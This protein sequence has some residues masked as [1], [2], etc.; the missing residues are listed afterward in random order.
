MAPR[1]SD[2]SSLPTKTCGSGLLCQARR[3]QCMSEPQETPCS[4]KSTARVDFKCQGICREH[5]ACFRRE[6]PVAKHSAVLAP[7]R[8]PCQPCRVTCGWVAARWPLSSSHA[9]A[10]R[11]CATVPEVSATTESTTY[12]PDVIQLPVED[13]H[14]LNL[15]EALQAAP[16]LQRCVVGHCLLHLRQVEPQLEQPAEQLGQLGRFW[17][18]LCGTRLDEGHSRTSWQ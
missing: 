13:A 16:V 11:E 18:Y 7:A 6:T 9:A 5:S 12:W 4:K 17:E 3:Q 15:R 8:T 1:C 14:G 2:I 10:S